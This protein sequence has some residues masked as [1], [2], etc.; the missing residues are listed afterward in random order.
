MRSQQ[1]GAWAAPPAPLPLPPGASAPTL[2]SVL[3]SVSLNSTSD[4]R[5]EMDCPLAYR[6]RCSSSRLITPSWLVSIT[7]NSCT[8]AFVG[9]AGQIRGHAT[10]ACG[11]T[12]QG[13]ISG[14][15]A[16]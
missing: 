11:S 3:V 7:G 6:W 14:L 12:G 4:R 10:A 8:A 1:Q 13:P 2:P 16:G 5:R 9:T 15:M